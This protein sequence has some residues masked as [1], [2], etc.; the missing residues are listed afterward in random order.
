MKKVI[1]ILFIA[2]CCFGQSHNP[3]LDSLT[4]FKN[5]DNNRLDHLKRYTL[6]EKHNKDITRPR[7]LWKDTT[8]QYPDSLYH[9]FYKEWYLKN[10][11]PHNKE[12]ELGIHLNPPYEEWKFQFIPTQPP[13]LNQP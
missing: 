4:K 9:Q 11:K 1:A 2:G 13:E 12:I 6:Q 8:Q 10:P 3:T 5:Q 7:G